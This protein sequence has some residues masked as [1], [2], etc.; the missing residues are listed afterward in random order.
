MNFTQLNKGQRKF[1]IDTT[2][3]KYIKSED[4][5][6]LMLQ[7][8]RESIKVLGLYSYES[9]NFG[10]QSNIILEGGLILNAPKSFNEIANIILNDDL[11]VDSIKKGECKIKIQPYQSKRF[12]KICHKIVFVE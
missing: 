1:D 10:T 6:S 3:Y 11:M 7:E 12:N 8:K 4:L 5:Y 2:N 9:K